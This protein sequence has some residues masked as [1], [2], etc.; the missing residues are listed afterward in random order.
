MLRFA[1]RGRLPD[2][3]RHSGSSCGV[4]DAHCESWRTGLEPL[5][6]TCAALARNQS[7]LIPSGQASIEAPDAGVIAIARWIEPQDDGTGVVLLRRSRRVLCRTGRGVSG[8]E[9]SDGRRTDDQSRHPSATTEATGWITSLRMGDV[10]HNLSPHGSIAKRVRDC[11]ERLPS[12]DR[13]LFIRCSV[14]RGNE[15]DA[16]L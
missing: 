11:A 8:G 7:L 6:G 15:G 2:G 16:G 1:G 12:P 5:L 9:Q 14:R 13:I 4:Y 10:G 3:R